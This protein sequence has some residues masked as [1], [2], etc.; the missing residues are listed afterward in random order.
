MLAGYSY[1]T[2]KELKQI[3]DNTIEFTG[4]AYS[5]LKIYDKIMACKK[6]NVVCD[7][8]REEIERSI[9]FVTDPYYRFILEG[10]C[11][12]TKDTSKITIKFT[13]F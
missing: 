12:M 4:D 7:K 3:D 10:G 6:I 9:Q 1:E 13:K 5:L 2:A 11:N 8:T